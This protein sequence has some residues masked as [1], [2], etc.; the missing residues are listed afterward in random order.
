[1]EVGPLSIYRYS[2]TQVYRTGVVEL[3]DAMVDWIV[4]LQASTEA[5]WE[6][7]AWT[8]GKSYPNGD[9]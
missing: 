7:C 3:T 4:R 1:M 2:K 6:G 8:F 9:F 5:E